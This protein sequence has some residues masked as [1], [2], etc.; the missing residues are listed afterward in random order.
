[1]GSS[2]DDGGVKVTLRNPRREVEVRGP[3]RVHALLTEL[4]V[5]RE[6]VL[7]IRGDTLVTGDALL[8][9]TDDVEVRPVISGGAR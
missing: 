6:S 5:N 3:K 9:D 4:G 2:R 8:A 7:V 1:M